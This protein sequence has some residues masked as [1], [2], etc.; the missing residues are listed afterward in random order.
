MAISKG[1][2]DPFVTVTRILGLTANQPANCTITAT[3]SWLNLHHT[4]PF[5]KLLS[6]RNLLHPRQIYP[7]LL[8][9]LYI[10]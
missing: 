8:S 3:H 6:H 1:A 4:I 5:K 10:E 7:G 9:E 2:L